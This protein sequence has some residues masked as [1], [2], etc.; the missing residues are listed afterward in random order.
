MRRFYSA[1]FF[2]FG[3]IFLSGCVTPPASLGTTVAPSPQK[4]IEH[5]QTEDLVIL[6]NVNYALNQYF[7]E[8]KGTPYRWG[9]SN[10]KGID[11]SAF[12]Q[13]AYHAIFEHSL[14]RTTTQQVKNGKKVAL[15]NAN[16]GDLVFFKTGSR[17]YHVGIY[18]GEREFM[19][20]STS[21]GVIIS[22]LDN[23][24]WSAR[25]WQVRSYIP[26]P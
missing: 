11:C 18:I 22:T 14:P 15:T 9:G 20:A 26:S 19:H 5:D 1:T 8:W 10:K 23:P 16:Y 3:G 12:T 25:F 7:D 2:C 24:Y 4:N 17:R 13:Q 6:K 21:K